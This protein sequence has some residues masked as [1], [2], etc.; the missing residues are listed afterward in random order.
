MVIYPSKG[1]NGYIPFNGC[2]IF[3]TSLKPSKNEGLHVFLLF[4]QVL[5]QKTKIN[6]G[7]IV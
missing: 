7:I 4:N 5:K 2:I 6:I 3:P 1:V